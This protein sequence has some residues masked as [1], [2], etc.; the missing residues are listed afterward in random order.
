MSEPAKQLDLG[1]SK[2]RTRW[3]RL[4][5][6]GWYLHHECEICGAVPAPYGEGFSGAKKTVGRWYCRA[7]WAERVKGGKA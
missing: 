7:H 4:P 5:E 6:R 1:N 3:E 2:P